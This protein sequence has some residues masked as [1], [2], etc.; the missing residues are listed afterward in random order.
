MEVRH[1]TI[2]VPNLVDSFRSC[3]KE[4]EKINTYKHC[5]RENG[6]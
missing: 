3:M 2:P 6:Y 5:L 4:R 1:S